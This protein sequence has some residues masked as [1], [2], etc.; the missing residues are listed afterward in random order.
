MSQSFI[1]LNKLR[2]LMKSK[3]YFDRIIDAYIVPTT[4]PH[5]VFAFSSLF[6]LINIDLS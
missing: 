4:D 2:Q 3:K 1:L 5:R 6:L